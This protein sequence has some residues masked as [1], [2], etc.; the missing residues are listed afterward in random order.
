[1]LQTKVMRQLPR[2]HGPFHL[3][4]LNLDSQDCRL[5][6]S[7]FNGCLV[8]F[9][10]YYFLSEFRPIRLGVWTIL[11]QFFSFVSIALSTTKSCGLPFFFISFFLSFTLSWI[12]PLS[13]N[14]NDWFVIMVKLK[15]SLRHFFLNQKLFQTSIRQPILIPAKR[16][17]FLVVA[18]IVDNSVQ[19]TLVSFCVCLHL[20]SFLEITEFFF[21]S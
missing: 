1:M 18:F 5:L 3:P 6:F 4:L 13:Q 17:F 20:L 12:F 19:L 9:F 10:H 2:G 15:F 11:F 21:Q 16:F 7:I 14:Y 8:G